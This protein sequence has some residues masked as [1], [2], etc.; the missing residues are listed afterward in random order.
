M[1]NNPPNR[2][3]SWAYLLL[4]ALFA[5]VVYMFINYPLITIGTLIAFI[6]IIKGSAARKDRRAVEAFYRSLSASYPEISISTQQRCFRNTLARV[7]SGIS[8]Y[9]KQTG[10]TVKVVSPVV[11][12]FN[13]NN[14]NLAAFHLLASWRGKNGREYLPYNF[15]CSPA[16][17]S[18]LYDTVVSRRATEKDFPEFD[19]VVDL[20]RNSITFML[21]AENPERRA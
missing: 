3:H 15:Q 2:R 17:S 13:G 9:W 11:V 19:M 7:S 1:D 12:C 8:N 20:E 10:Y 18:K 14:R 16:L 4:A 21:R 6:G 5:V